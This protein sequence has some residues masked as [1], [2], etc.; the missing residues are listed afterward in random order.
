MQPPSARQWTREQLFVPVEGLTPSSVKSHL[1]NPDGASINQWQARNHGSGRHAS[2]PKNSHE[3]EAHEEEPCPLEAHRTLKHCLI[4]YGIPVTREHQA[5]EAAPWLFQPS[6]LPFGWFQPVTS[7]PRS[8]SAV[9]VASSQTPHLVP[10]MGLPSSTGPALDGHM[11]N[12]TTTANAYH[13]QDIPIT[14]HTK[15]KADPQSCERALVDYASA[16]QQTTSPT[17]IQSSLST[18]IDPG[19]YQ[20]QETAQARRSVEA[21]VGKTTL[22]VRNI[23]ARYRQQDLLKDF[24]VPDG[25]FDLF[26]LPHSFKLGHTVGYAIIN[27]TRTS[28]AQDFHRQWHGKTLPG[29][30]KITPLDIL[31][32]RFQGFYEN[33]KC[34][35]TSGVI[36]TKG[37]RFHPVVFCG[38]RRID[39]MAALLALNLPN[40]EE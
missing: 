32:T 38:R 33:M 28:H 13:D 39:F 16:G 15:E 36:R 7:T 22:V 8:S 30:S 29:G 10:T 37:T 20:Q 2:H 35:S 6:N 21:L 1:I 34:L 19:W 40:S 12:R 5:T 25:T 9:A 18:G 3:P 14:P 17:G 4:L 11:F 24:W 26:F 23:P 31:A 27:F